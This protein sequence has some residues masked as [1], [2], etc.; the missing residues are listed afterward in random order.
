MPSPGS[1][2]ALCQQLGHTG[3]VLCPSQRAEEVLAVAAHIRAG[4]AGSLP[5]PVAMELLAIASLIL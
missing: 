3:V 5:V 2:R 4:D 1:S